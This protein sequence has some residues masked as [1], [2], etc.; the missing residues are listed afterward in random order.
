MFCIKCGKQL[1]DEAAFCFA[2]GAPVFSGDSSPATVAAPVTVSSPVVAPIS[3]PAS[4][5][6]GKP[7]VASDAV[8]ELG[9]L[10]IDGGK[11][12]FITHGY[13]KGLHSQLWEADL[14]G[15]NKKCL[16]DFDST[17]YK[18]ECYFDS[19]D[20]YYVVKIGRILVIRAYDK[21]LNYVNYYYDIDKNVHGVLE[22][23]SKMP[24]KVSQDGKYFVN[25]VRDEQYDGAVIVELRTPWEVI[26]NQPYEKV[27]LRPDSLYIY[28][29]YRDIKFNEGDCF[30]INDRTIVISFYGDD[31]YMW[32]KCNI[33]NQSDIAVSAHGNYISDS[34]LIG[35]KNLQLFK[36]VEGDAYACVDTD[37]MRDRATVMM[38][39]I[40]LANKYGE[41]AH[42]TSYGEEYDVLLNLTNGA[43][44][45]V[46]K[47]IKVFEKT[48]VRNIRQTADGFYK[49][50]YNDAVT[51][52]Y[53]MPTSELFAVTNAE[54]YDDGEYVTPLIAHAYKREFN[55]LR[56]AALDE[57]VY[58][59]ENTKDLKIASIEY[60]MERNAELAKEIANFNFY[61][62]VI[63][64]PDGKRVG[65]TYGHKKGFEGC[66]DYYYNLYEMN[67]DGTYKHLNCGSR[68]GIEFL[69]I[70]KNYA[71]W[72]DVMTYRYD[73][74]T[75]EFIETHDKWLRDEY[76]EVRA[77]ASANQL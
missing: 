37:D 33:D 64:L 51:K 30:V 28:S 19:D 44:K 15:N 43:K 38:R 50:S 40:S 32:L 39:G 36:F 65:F 60:V 47:N 75:G 7:N 20:N 54:T 8:A 17:P 69:H 6:D 58:T 29:C 70:Y 14:K 55:P 27:S 45:K 56:N 22:N 76:E 42:F 1:P 11:M 5:A 49:Y 23:T 4:A 25:C 9:N 67:L 10:F 77:K 34:D 41:I 16:L 63:T 48:G 74:A 72:V 35:E 53:F 26:N 13:E 59:Y 3:K 2:C 66:K 21:D 12:Y 31:K 57:N 68:G 52:I 71:Y 18:P 62:K 24:Y 46:D 73:F 61:S